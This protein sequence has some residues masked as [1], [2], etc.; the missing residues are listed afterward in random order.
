MGTRPWDSLLFSHSIL[1]RILQAN[2]EMKW[3]IEGTKEAPIWGNTLQG[4]STS[5]QDT[6]KSTIITQYVPLV[7]RI[8]GARSTGIEVEKIMI[9]ITL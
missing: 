4:L 7:L 9:A 2:R 1:P 6:P 8:L 5:L 3:P